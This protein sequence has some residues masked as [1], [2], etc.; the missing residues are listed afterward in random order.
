MWHIMG[1]ECQLLRSICL[2][3]YYFFYCM[4]AQIKPSTTTL[5]MEIYRH[6]TD[7]EIRPLNEE[8][9]VQVVGILYESSWFSWYS[10]ISAMLPF[11]NHI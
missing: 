11:L 5:H 3:D 9:V 6:A 2:I 7:V 10:F 4:K 8:R 1:F